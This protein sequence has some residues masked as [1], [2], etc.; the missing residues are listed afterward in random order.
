M[1]PKVRKSENEVE[2]YKERHG[3]SREKKHKTGERG[4]CM[5]AN[6]CAVE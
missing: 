2:C 3:R 1:T 6:I 5:N 4:V